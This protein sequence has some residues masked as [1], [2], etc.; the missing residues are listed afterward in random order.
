M[1]SSLTMLCVPCQGAD[2]HQND[3]ICL[4]GGSFHQR[5][6]EWWWK[7]GAT[8]VSLRRVT[9][10]SNA[11]PVRRVAGKRERQVKASAWLTLRKRT[12]L[13]PSGSSGCRREDWE[14]KRERWNGRH[15]SEPTQSERVRERAEGENWKWQPVPKEPTVYKFIMP[16]T[17]FRGPPVD[18]TRSS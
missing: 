11:S 7:V 6:V 15:Q 9:E 8:V 17:G 16:Q 3:M 1:G 10:M 13:L 18:A 2:S 14:P 12:K 4:S 5:R